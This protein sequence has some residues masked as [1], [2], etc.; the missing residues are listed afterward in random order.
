MGYYEAGNASLTTKHYLR[1]ALSKHA[2]IICYG[3]EGFNWGNG[4][5]VSKL[6]KKYKPEVILLQGRWPTHNYPDPGGRIP[7]ENLE[8]V[9]VPKVMFFNELRL[10]VAER[11]DYVNRNKIDM[12]LWGTLHIMNQNRKS[13]FKGHIAKWCPW[14]VNINVFKAYQQERIYDVAVLGSMKYYPL[15]KKIR[16]ALEWRPDLKVFNTARPKRGFNLDPKKAFIHENYAKAI[17]RAKMLIFNAPNGAALK[18]YFEG[19]ACKTLVLAPIPI[20][21]ESLRFK[22][23][24]NFVEINEDNFVEKVLYYQKNEEERKRIALNGYRTVRK[25]HSSDVRAR[26]IIKNIEELM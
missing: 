16:D 14:S 24:K 6:E 5:D 11:I 2:E 13:L 10:S 12:T 4:L 18:K 1:L 3:P 7:W 25:H 8:K 20:D 26:Q 21:A 23:G 9:T 22:A 19:M 15:R 17:A